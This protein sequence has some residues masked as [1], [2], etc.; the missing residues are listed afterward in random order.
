MN[1]VVEPEPGTVLFFSI[2]EELS[3]EIEIDSSLDGAI[4][5]FCHLL[6]WQHSVR[7]ES[8]PAVKSSFV[9]R[10]AVPAPVF[11]LIFAKPIVQL[12]YSEIITVTKAS[13]HA[14]RVAYDAYFLIVDVDH[15]SQSKLVQIGRASCR[16]RV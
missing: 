14:R 4:N 11:V 5:A 16:E 1:R 3:L 13:E 15:R 8:F 10:E 7:R 12:P 6:L 2:V 9:A